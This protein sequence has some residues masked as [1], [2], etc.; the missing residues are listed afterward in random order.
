MTTSRLAPLCALAVAFSLPACSG[1][2]PSAPVPHVGPGTIVSPTPTNGIG[3]IQHVVII[4]QENRSVNN[5]FQGFPGAD[6]VPK[7]KNSKGETITLQPVSLKV[8]YVIDHSAYAMFAA[9]NGTGKLPG[10]DCRMNGFDKEES[11]GGPA[12]PEYVYVPHDESKPYWDMAHEW[13]LG[14]RFFPSQ[15]DES[16][17]SHQ[18]IIA[19]QAQGSV[20]LPYGYWGCDGGPSDL[21]TT[22]TKKR[23]FGSPQVACFDYTTLGD[24]LDSAKLTW[25]FYTSKV[26]ADDGGGEWSAYQAVKHIRFGPDW[27]TDVITPQ[28]QF[29]KDVPN[30]KLAN[31]TWITPTCVDSDH[32]NCG[33]GLGPSWV[34]SLVNTVGESKFWDS[35]AI[36]V[37][38][39][40]WGGLYD[41]IAP[42]MEDYDG[43]GMR[44][45]LLVISPYAKKNHIS[46]VQYEH[47]SILRFA[48][49]AFGLGRLAASDAR[50]NSPAL[51]CFDFTQKPRRFVPIKA[52]KS[53]VFFLHQ[54]DDGRPPDY[55]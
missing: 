40:D 10:T 49:D 15:L 21:V 6:T 8:P 20:D 12:N 35:T 33:G 18:Y 43:L 31:V 19:G 16:F 7:A 54:I 27:K 1:N 51:D 9:C 13:S 3:K 32:V 39:D 22:L 45:G 24:E 34:T 47:G 5:M 11:F 36:F 25:K 44:T 37:F 23:T 17:V 46:K 26:N 55:E 28:K 30:G 52:P 41:P 42:P 38:W 29:L 4:V 14:T 53:K 48:E 2:A 50:A